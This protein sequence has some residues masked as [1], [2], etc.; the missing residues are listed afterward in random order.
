MIFLSVSHAAPASKL[1]HGR[2]TDR[3]LSMR[4][5]FGCGQALFDF[6]KPEIAPIDPRLVGRQEH[7]VFEL[8]FCLQ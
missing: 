2:T 1:I 6:L 3:L 4:D 5:E 8:E 7:S